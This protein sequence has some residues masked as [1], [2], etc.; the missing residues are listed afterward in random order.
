MAAALM[1]ACQSDVYHIRGEARCLR[2]GTVLYIADG[3]DRQALPFDSAIVADGRFRLSGTTDTTQL[4]RI[5]CGVKP[6][7]AD[8]DD[9]TLEEDK[10]VTAEEVLFFLEPG[11]IYIELSSR[12]GRS[13][14]SGTKVNNEWQ[15]LQ[16]RVAQADRKI[17]S[18]VRSSSQDKHRQAREVY[19]DI[20]RDIRDAALRNSDN[21]L[22]I[23]ISERYEQ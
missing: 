13:R 16:D 9:I 4:C 12:K 22:G 5:S 21:A 6:T 19:D 23:F 3:I 2:D 7:A 14:V 11:N 10:G 1:A 17:R 8:S 20:D 15:R 18:I